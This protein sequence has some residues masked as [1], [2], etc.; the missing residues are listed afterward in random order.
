MVAHL[1][2]RLRQA[3]HNPAILTRGYQRRSAD[4]VVVL[5]RGH[6]APSALTGDEAQIFLR[7]G[8]AHV[9]IG[10]NRYAVGV[11]M[12]RQFRP[13]VFLLDDGFQ[14]QKLARRHDIVLD[15]RSESIR[16][17]RVSLGRVSRAG[18]KPCGARRF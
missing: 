7:G 13:D 18:R 11:R 16:R 8:D 10:K 5:E 9:G 2:K 14:H 6:P 3:G 12:E 4:A 17:R 15:R 1:A